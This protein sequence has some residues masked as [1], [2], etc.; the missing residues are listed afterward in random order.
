[1]SIK[2]ALY[3]LLTVIVGATIAFGQMYLCGVMRILISSISAVLKVWHRVTLVVITVFSIT[4]IIPV[5]C[6]LSSRQAYSLEYRVH[7]NN[8]STLTAVLAIGVIEPGD[9]ERLNKFLNGMRR[10]SNAAIYLA[11]G[12]G[13]LYEGIRLGIYFREH[14]I[15]TVV[16]GGYDC[17]SSCALAFLGGTD[18]RGIPWRSS[19]TNSRLG[20]HAFKGIAEMSIS[21]DEVQK[22]V[23]DILLY[24]KT[25]NAP[26]DLLIAGFSTPSR[27]IFWVS[28]Q[29]I[30]SLGI[31]LWSNTINRFVC[32]N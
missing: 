24:G 4:S 19:S 26:I 10:A 27:D 31:K 13:N 7:E 22:I 29:D 5:T 2:T 17:A 6:L 3:A 21:T 23:A 11:S 8:K 20:F 12:G 18:N 32:N 30:C 1:M 16:E 25:V 14:R 9:T 28:Q 15:K